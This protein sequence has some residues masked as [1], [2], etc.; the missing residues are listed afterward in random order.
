MK[1]RR[2]LFRDPPPGG[3]CAYAAGCSR[4]AAPGRWCCHEHTAR[5]DELSRLNVEADEAERRLRA[6]RRAA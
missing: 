1:R 6:R 4:P 3:D 5:M 2:L